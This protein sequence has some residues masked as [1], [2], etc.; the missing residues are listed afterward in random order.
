MGL[1]SFRRRD[2]CLGGWRGWRLIWNLLG[3]ILLVTRG[4]KLDSGEVYYDL[5]SWGS[6]LC[7]CIETLQYYN[8][9]VSESRGGRI[10]YHIGLTMLSH[11]TIEASQNVESGVSGTHCR[12]YLTHV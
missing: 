6:S 9:G 10:F 1:G 5:L 8:G 7:S 3:D 11:I 2:V 4:R 12:K